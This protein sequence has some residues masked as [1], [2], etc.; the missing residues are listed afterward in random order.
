MGEATENGIGRTRAPQERNAFVRVAVIV[1]IAVL[2]NVFVAY[3]VRVFYS[4]PEYEVFCPEVSVVEPIIDRETCLSSGGQWTEADPSEPIAVGGGKVSGYC[5]E[6]F[7]CRKEY[8]QAEDRYGRDLFIVFVAVGAALL[9]GSPFLTGSKTVS[10]GLSL[11]GVIALIFGSLRYWSAMD[12]RLRV[13]VSG[14]ALVAL[15]V[16]AWKRFKETDL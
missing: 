3:F 2:I 6:Q 14:V 5:D 13:I 11:G 10:S 8:K 9:L 7:S 12:D 16:I 15:L 1:G 4:V